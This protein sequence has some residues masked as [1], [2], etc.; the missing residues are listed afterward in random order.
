MASSDKNSPEKVTP[1]VLG[2]EPDVSRSL[3]ACVRV[4]QAK[5]YIEKD[6]SKRKPTVVVSTA[7]KA[8]LEARSYTIEEK[9][10]ESHQRRPRN[11]QLHEVKDP[12]DYK[13]DIVLEYTDDG[14][15]KLDSKEAY[16][17][18]CHK[19]HGK[20]PGKNKIDKVL[21]KQAMENKLKETLSKDEPLASATLMAQKQKELKT[22]YIILSKGK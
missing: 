21:K 5:G 17:Y 20:G 4:A 13:P 8:K 16:R 18:L 10:D 6:T 9:K 19:F 7:K 2:D 3:L 14:G 12:D 1:S 22:P 11:N 15:R